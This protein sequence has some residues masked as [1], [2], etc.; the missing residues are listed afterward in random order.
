M[1]NGKKG[2][3]TDHSIRGSGKCLT[4]VLDF[5]QGRVRNEL[6]LER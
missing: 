6:K 1:G 4:H 3:D 2:M 5:E